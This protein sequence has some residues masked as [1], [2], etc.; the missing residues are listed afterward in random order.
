MSSSICLKV[1]RLNAE[2]LMG[3]RFDPAQDKRNPLYVSPIN[4]LNILTK[5]LAEDK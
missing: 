5:I 2:G 4:I 1:E 3:C